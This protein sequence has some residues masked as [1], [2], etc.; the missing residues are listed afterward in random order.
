MNTQSIVSRIETQQLPQWNAGSPGYIGMEGASHP[1]DAPRGSHHFGMAIKRYWWVVLLL[2]AVVAIPSTILIFQHVKPKYV[3]TGSVNVLPTRQNP[4]SGEEGPSPFYTEYLRTQAELMKNPYI[5]QRATEDVRLKKFD[6]F[7]DLP[8]QVRY[9]QDHL[10]ITA[11]PGG[12]EDITVSMAHEDAQA[13]TAIVD[14]VIDA[15]FFL[16]KDAEDKNVDQNLQI[17]RGL[18]AQTQKDIQDTQQQ[19]NALLEDSGGAWSDEDRKVLGEVI[20]NAKQTVDKLQNDRLNLQS[21][22][23]A[24]KDRKDVS[25]KDYKSSINTDADPQ[26][27]DWMKQRMQLVVKDNELAT[28]NHATPEQRDRKAIA[29]QIKDLDAKVA[30]RRTEILNTAWVTYE[31]SQSVDR[32]KKMKDYQAELDAVDAQIDAL[33]KHVADQE[34]IARDLGNKAQPIAAL[35]EHI[36]DAKDAQKRYSARIEEIQNQ[37]LA[38][39]RVTREAQTVEPKTPAVDGRVKYS[40]AANGAGLLLGV[41]VMLILMKLR[42]RLEHPDDLPEAFQPLVVG[43]VSDAGQSVRGLHGRMNRKIL[44]EEMRLLHANLLPPGRTK[45]KIMMVT[46]PT[47]ANGKTSISSQLA[48]SLAKSGL[49]VLLIDADLRKRDLTSMYDVGFRPGLAELLQSQPPELV[50]PIEL[51]PNLRVLG[52]GSKLDRNPVELLQRREFHESLNLLQDNFDVIIVDTPPALVVADARLIARSCDEVL[53]VVRMQVSSP[54]EV[55][56][57]LDAIS[58]I[59]GKTPKII[60]N[61]VAHRQSYYKYKF[62]YASD[63]ADDTVEADGG[64]TPTTVEAAAAEVAADVGVIE[65]SDKG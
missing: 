20:S 62:S 41:G 18:E 50:R 10:V 1:T 30:A 48:V 11:A 58:R 35:R 23:D 65:P 4:V 9:L 17:V 43:T 47:P 32:D 21:Q 33:N 24:L 31:A 15:Y 45:R 60:I 3:A 34:K 14:S 54:K 59:T 26:I 38:P 27:Q 63:A 6:W 56:Q 36:T 37:L 46:S 13:A 29:Q 8:D 7:R 12:T 64:H 53:C 39:G 2:W 61:G 51:L 16:R 22:V 25:E 57:T 19:L 49:D 42:N 55:N 28:T 5:L 44:G 40:A 52:A